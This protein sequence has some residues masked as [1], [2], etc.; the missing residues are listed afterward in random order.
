MI[1]KHLDCEPKITEGVFVAE[2]ATVIGKVTLEPSSSVWFGAVIRGD[3]ENIHIGQ[4][5]NIQDNAVVHTSSG[6]PTTVGNDVTVGHGAIVHGCTIGNRV[7]IGMGAIILDGAVIEDD[8]MIGAGTLVPPG[9]TIPSGHLAV[10][11]PAKVIR[12][13][14][15]D[16]KQSLLD[17]ALRY[18]KYASTY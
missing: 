3:V 8:C 14:T 4:R 6:F 18:A 13:L 9:K 7:L 15:E 1:K 2:N 12:A 5:S 16:E 11:S 17:S 10:G